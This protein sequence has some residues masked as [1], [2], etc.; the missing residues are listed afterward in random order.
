MDIADRN[1]EL[2][3]L[4][5]MLLGSA[6]SA[7]SIGV[8]ADELGGIEALVDP[9]KVVEPIGSLTAFERRPSSWF[10]NIFNQDLGQIEPGNEYH[11]VDT[12]KIGTFAG[13]D[14]WVK[15]QAIEGAGG[16]DEVCEPGCWAYFGK[17]DAQIMLD[18]GSEGGMT[19]K[20]AI[21]NFEIHEFMRAPGI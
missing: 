18:F 12:K 13:A 6:L 14:I 11:V 4:A 19:Q 16:S 2:S 1:Y 10:G 15:L 8:H 7:A 21:G 17:E 9:S 3:K 5:V 20:L